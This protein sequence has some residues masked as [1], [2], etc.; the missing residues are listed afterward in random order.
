[1]FSFSGG[2]KSPPA[3]NRVN[4]NGAGGHNVPALFQKA[5]SPWKKGSGG[6]KSKK[7]IGFYSVSGDLECWDQ[8]S[9]KSP[10]P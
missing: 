1:M 4:P 2:F 6:P 5:I 7:E 10:A 8:A 3:T 9:F